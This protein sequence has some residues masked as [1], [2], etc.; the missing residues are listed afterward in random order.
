[1]RP[2]AFS[3]ISPL[4]I[5]GS[6]GALALLAIQC[7]VPVQAQ[8][9]TA[10]WT[11]YGPAVHG[12]SGKFNAFAYV[13]KNPKVIFVGGG[14]GN[15]PRESP[16]QAGIYRTSDGGLNWE[17]ADDGLTNPDGTISSVVNGLWVD[18]ANPSIVL[19]ATEFGGTFRSRDGGNSWTNIDRA[20]STQFAQ[21]GSTLYLAS[22]KGVLSSKDDG[23]SWSVSLPSASGAT[24]VVTAAGATFAGDAGGEVYVLK[25]KRWSAVGHPG[26]GA[27]HD[28]AIDP[29]NTSVVY[30][31]VDDEGVW[32]EVMYGSVDGGSTWNRVYCRCSIGAQAI[33][34]SR[35]VPN[36]LY[37]GDDGGGYIFYITA[38]G[39]P[40][41]KR[42]RGAKT[43]VSDVRYVFPEPGKYKGTEACYFTTDQGLYYDADCAAG[44]PQLLTKYVPNFLAYSV[45]LTRDAGNIVVPLQDYGAI[46]GTDDGTKLH[47]LQYSSEGGESF[48]NPYDRRMCYLAHPD[49]GLFTSVDGCNTFGKSAGSGIESLAFEPPTGSTMLAIIRDDS[50]APEVAR[51]LNG[52]TTWTPAFRHFDDP[53]QVVVSPKEP[54]TLIVA[55]GKAKFTNHVYVSHDFG[56]TW[57]EVR[58]LPQAI[59]LT[60]REQYYPAHRFYAAADPLVPRT[61]LLADHDPATNNVLIF[62]SVDDGRTFSLA[63]TFVEPPTQR[64]WPEIP[65]PPDEDFVPPG[66]RYYATRFYANRLAFDPQAPPGRRPAVVLTTRFGAFVSYDTG[67]RW[68]RIDNGAI[69]HHFIGVTWMDGYVYLASFGEGVLKSTTPLQ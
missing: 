56:A 23:A 17:T 63:S 31:N 33:A 22:R 1:V 9:G 29:F 28:L 14:W 19:A 42:S 8:R 5:A 34:F 10:E 6:I 48:V 27:I 40:R 50:T 24:S 35:I 26:T 68:Q 51:S 67:S 53:Y 25:G 12:G 66:A 54:R 69:P 13:R 3:A 2:P 65:E 58:G 21:V 20:E 43:A 57:R 44:S 61:I 55:T 18:Q 30:A 41:P 36:R 32:N 64:P 59:P 16:S 49:Q 37:F 52:G 39:E 38:N 47:F 15:T 60:V 7:P 46:S 45:S 4:V 62:R 11:S